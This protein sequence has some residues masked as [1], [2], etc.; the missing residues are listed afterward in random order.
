[1]R[2]LSRVVEHVPAPESGHDFA[3]VLGALASPVRLALIN[4]L[5]TPRTLKEIDVK[6]W[7][8][9]RK[10][11]RPIARQTVK[12]H[13]DRLIQIGIVATRP[14]QRPY[15]QTTEYLL[16][17]QRLFSFAEQ[18]RSLAKIR[19]VEEASM[20]T[21]LARTRGPRHAIRG[22]CLV[23]AKGLDE[24]QVYSLAPATAGARR[25]VLGRGQEADVVIDYDPYVSN[26]NTV[27]QWRQEGYEIAD[28]PQSRNGT[29]LN[30]QP[31]PRDGTAHPLRHGDL[32]GVGRCILVFRA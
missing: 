26:R 7:D 16:N 15:G 30:F 18:F 3:A 12:E 21:V 29:H 13:L 17:R 2:P 27:I 25:W 4:H 10:A 1:M 28:D 23:V 11:Q 5:R 31:L 24:G 20:D 22:P 6:V 8:P 14:G 9:D 19:P 32:V